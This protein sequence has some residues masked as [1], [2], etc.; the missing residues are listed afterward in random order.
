MPYIDLDEEHRK[1]REEVEKR[2]ALLEG[3]IEYIESLL[4]RVLK[5]EKND[6]AERD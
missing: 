3:R 1:F 5:G 4:L 2:L 6:R